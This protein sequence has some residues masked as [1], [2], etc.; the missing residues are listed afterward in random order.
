MA[1]NCRPSTASASAVVAVA[2]SLPL[3]SGLHVSLSLIEICTLKPYSFA[4]NESGFGSRP[5]FATMRPPYPAYS[6]MSMRSTLSF[7]TYV[8]AASRVGVPVT[9]SM[10]SGASPSGFVTPFAAA[11]VCA[12]AGPAVLGAS[13]PLPRPSHSHRPRATMPS[14]RTSVM[15]LPAAEPRARWIISI[16]LFRDFLRAALLRA[17]RS[18]QIGGGRLVGEILDAGEQ[19]ALILEPAIRFIERGRQR[20]QR[21]RDGVLVRRQQ[22]L[23][24]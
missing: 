8:F 7:G 22:R 4:K 13:S 9:G 24:A 6:L 17:P 11:P 3:L 21:G 18:E 19:L 15:M 10:G 20:V 1:S 16:L 23:L 2:A 14:S 5:P 12:A